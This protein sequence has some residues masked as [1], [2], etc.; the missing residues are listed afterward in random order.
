MSDCLDASYQNES[1]VCNNA[2]QLIYNA[3]QFLN[4]FLMSFNLI[5]ES[6]FLMRRFQKRQYLL[7][8]KYQLKIKIS[9]FM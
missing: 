4:D 2:E 8:N 9:I 3:I 1:L 6:I 7:E 5:C